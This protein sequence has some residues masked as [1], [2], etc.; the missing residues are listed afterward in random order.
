MTPRLRSRCRTWRTTPLD[1]QQRDA[2]QEAEH[3]EAAGELVPDEVAEHRDQSGGQHRG[4][5][6]DL[7]LLGAGAEGLDGVGALGGEEQ[8]PDRHDPRAGTDGE[9]GVGVD[10]TD[11]DVDVDAE[12]PGEDDR[13]DEDDD[14]GQRDESEQPPELAGCGGARTPPGV[15]TVVPEDAHGVPAP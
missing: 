11:P 10:G 8:H 2:D 14:V 5:R 12:V 3:E 7:E 13:G 9:L 4:Q 6:D 15:A 1:E